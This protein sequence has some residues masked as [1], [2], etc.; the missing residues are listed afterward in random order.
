MGNRQPRTGDHSHSETRRAYA[1]ELP[2][3]LEHSLGAGLRNVASGIRQ[4]VDAHGQRRVDAKVEV[5][6]SRRGCGPREP[7]AQ[8]G[9]HSRTCTGGDVDDTF[10]Q[11]VGEQAGHE[12][13]QQH[14]VRHLRPN[15]QYNRCEQ[16]RARHTCA[17][18]D[19]ASRIG[20]RDCTDASSATHEL[21]QTGLEMRGSAH[22][23]AA[24]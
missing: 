20:S 5:L 3:K 24:R 4:H 12:L 14:A 23:P 7:R 13:A 2:H 18:N 9:G 16:Q 11:A 8:E 10:V 19:W 22:W 15:G 1:D 17:K 6:A 21:S